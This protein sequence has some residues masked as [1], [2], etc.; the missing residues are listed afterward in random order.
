MPPVTSH[1]LDGDPPP[2]PEQ[3]VAD[4]V[5]LFVFFIFEEGA[6]AAPVFVLCSGMVRG[7][8]EVPVWSA[9]RRVPL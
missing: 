7:S 2:S 1:P 8:G 4:K 9:W 3:V 5:G 6:V